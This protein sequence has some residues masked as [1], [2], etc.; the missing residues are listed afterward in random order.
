MKLLAACF[1]LTGS[2]AG[3]RP[4]SGLPTQGR[5]Q[6]S[7]SPPSC[8]WK[9]GPTWSRTPSTPP[10]LPPR[11]RRSGRRG[12]LPHRPDAPHGGVQQPRETCLIT[13]S[14]FNGVQADLN[15]HGYG[16]VF[17]TIAPPYNTSEVRARAIAPQL[18]L[19]SSHKGAQK[20]NLIGHH[21]GGH[22]RAR[23]H[24]RGRPQL[25]EQGGVGDDHRDA[26]SRDEG[27]QSRARAR[28]GA[29]RGGDLR[30]S[31][32]RWCSCSS[33]GSTQSRAARTSWRRRPS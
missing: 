7:V 24:E 25:R 16:P 10:P 13:I 20:L 28:A 9:P 29:C 12:A 33:R 23:P 11:T 17:V 1:L 30:T 18:D 6:G 8:R 22:E 21:P 4:A 19:K 26:A 2:G 31:P 14:Y 3:A 27:G 32:T 5:T 15:S